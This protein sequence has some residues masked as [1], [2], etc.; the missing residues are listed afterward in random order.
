MKELFN[1]KCYC[2]EHDKDAYVIVT[3]GEKSYFGEYSVFTC[4]LTKKDDYKLHYVGS[5][6]TVR[7]VWGKAKDKIPT[8]PKDVPIRDL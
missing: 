7:E 6:A 3:R 2:Y 5:G 4:K 1:G 8:L